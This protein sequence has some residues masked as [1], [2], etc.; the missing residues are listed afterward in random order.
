MSGVGVTTTGPAADGA[1]V[2]PVS[3]GAEANSRAASLAMP[4]ADF[5]RDGEPVDYLTARAYFER[6]T[7]TR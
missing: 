7:A 5:E 4:L 1:D 3:F 2:E 6:D